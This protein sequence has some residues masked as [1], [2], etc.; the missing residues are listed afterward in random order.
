[1]IAVAERRRALVVE[2]EIMVAMHIEDL[3]IDLGVDVVLLATE[4]EQAIFSA[5]TQAEIDFAVLDINLG[6]HASFPVAAILR[7]RGI[8]F[9]FASGYGSKGVIEDYKDE[10]RLQKPFRERDLAR[11]LARLR[12][13]AARR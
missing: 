4:F 3:L 2:D 12:P 9:L 8:P 6:G 7:G 5:A 1:M 13:A 11:A 10:I